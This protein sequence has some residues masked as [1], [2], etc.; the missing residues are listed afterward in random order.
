MI[1]KGDGSLIPDTE[2][3]HKPVETVL[4]GPA[5]SAIG[6]RFLSGQGNALVIDVGGTTTDMALVDDFKMTIS[7]DGARVGMFETAV[8]A[9]RIRT[10]GIGGDSRI[11]IDAGG[12]VRVGP[13]RVVPLSRLAARFPT[14]RKRNWRFEKKAGARPTIFRPRILVFIQRK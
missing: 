8:K 2:A 10:A 12:T 4:S 9:A 3:I 7:E 6:G 5:A 14:G 11:S 13:E 1:V